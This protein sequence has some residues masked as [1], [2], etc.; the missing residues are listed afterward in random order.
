MSE[1]VSEWKGCCGYISE[2]LASKWTKVG[3]K[4]V[5]KSE[6]EIN[7]WKEAMLLC[8]KFEKK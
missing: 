7:I 8:A 4:R 3:E 2:Q 5:G 6:C 1:W